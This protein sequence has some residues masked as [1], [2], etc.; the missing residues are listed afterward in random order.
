MKILAAL[1]CAGFSAALLWATPVRAQ[2]AQ[3]APQE[4]VAQLDRLSVY[5]TRTAFEA[6]EVPGA[7]T[8]LDRET[9]DALQAST[10]SD[11]FDGVP[12]LRFE[13]GPRRT[14]QAPVL[15]GSTG[16]GVLVLFDGARQSFVS[17]HDGRFFV[18]PDLLQTVEVLRGPSS[19]L[20]G[21]GAIGGVLALRTVSADDLLGEGE[22]FG[23]RLRGGLQGASA[24]EGVGG[25]VFARSEAGAWD[26]LLSVR[27][28]NSGDIELGNDARLPSDDKVQSSLLK[29]T[30][31]VSEDL[32]FSASALFYEGDSRDPNNPQENNTEDSLFNELIPGVVLG[33]VD[34]NVT[35]ETWRGHAKFNPDNPLVDFSA[36]IWLANNEVEEAEVAADRVILRAVETLGAKFENHS[37]FNFSSARALTL[38]YGVEIYEDEQRGTDVGMDAQGVDGARAGVPGA[39]SLFTGAYVQ[40]AFALQEPG[41]LPGVLRVIPGLRYDNFE[42]DLDGGASVDDDEVS[43]KLGANFEWSAGFLLFA[44]YAEAFRAPTFNELFPSGVHFSVPCN[45]AYETPRG[46]MLPLRCAGNL[47]SLDNTFDESSAGLAPEDSHT[48]E[49]GLGFN[50][51][52]LGTVDGHLSFKG[53]YWSADVKNLIAPA[54]APPNFGALFGRYGASLAPGG[55]PFMNIP[56]QA[57][58]LDLVA[59]GPAMVPE[60]LTCTHF[61]TTSFVATPEAELDGVELEAYYENPFLYA[62]ATWSTIDGRNTRTGAPVGVLSPDRLF[63]DVGARSPEVGLRVGVRTT[64]AR[65]FDGVDE[66]GNAAPRAAYETFDLYASWS[67]ARGALAGFRLDFGVDN[68]TDEAYEVVAAG[69][70]EAGRSFKATLAWRA[71]W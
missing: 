52:N 62:R 51:D 2:D 43:F 71:N 10:A 16:A 65:S 27:L 55:P 8:V 18:E 7:V 28:R 48:W 45:T 40:A 68:L 35:S 57:C 32:E 36:N 41:G 6:F 58:D 21:S 19:A 63:L 70:F 50:L 69:A 54:I 53:S 9:M 42:T 4:W 56:G 26:G 20:Y 47:P 30:A 33:L 24:E 15:R 49:V 11:L 13:G 17:T 31:R 29:G 1:L 44:N 59:R 3:D 39:D 37:R 46:D 25:S 67:P 61:G 22:T 23:V 5:A 66:S 60:S 38:S 64:I 12:G 34:R 14:G